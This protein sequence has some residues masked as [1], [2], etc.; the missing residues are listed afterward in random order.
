MFR[1]CQT[2]RLRLYSFP[3][4]RKMYHNKYGI[5]KCPFQR[6]LSTAGAPERCLPQGL[7]QCRL[8]MSAQLALDLQQG[9]FHRHPGLGCRHHYRAGHYHPYQYRVFYYP[10]YILQ[11]LLLP[12]YPTADYCWPACSYPHP[13]KRIRDHSLHYPSRWM[14]FPAGRSC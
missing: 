3:S 4:I 12:Q 5:W 2:G 9:C 7:N 13:Q 1:W 8:P 10:Q 6:V 14:D 11:H